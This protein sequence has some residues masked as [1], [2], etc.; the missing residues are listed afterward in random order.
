MMI[1][2]LYYSLGPYWLGWAGLVLAVY[3][4]FIKGFLLVGWLVGLFRCVDTR[5]CNNNCLLSFILSLL[6]Y[7]VQEREETGLLKG[8]HI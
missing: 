8:L 5:I 1:N 3:Y 2:T 7:K 6:R 4:F